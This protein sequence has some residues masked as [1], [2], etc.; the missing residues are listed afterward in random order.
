MINFSLLRSK[1]HHNWCFLVGLRS[2][3]PVQNNRVQTKTCRKYFQNDSWM[4]PSNMD[5]HF[6]SYVYEQIYEFLCVVLKMCSECSYSVLHC[7][8]FFVCIGFAS[9]SSVQ[10]YDVT[11]AFFV[12]SPFKTARCLMFPRQSQHSKQKPRHHQ[13]THYR[14]HLMESFGTNAVC[15]VGTRFALVQIL[16][17]TLAGTRFVCMEHKPIASYRCLCYLAYPHWYE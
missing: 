4:F 12:C 1:R 16:T 9:C 10:W 17:V 14:C 2:D 5:D 8:T 13:P 7:C 3:C 11:V 6:C 15:H